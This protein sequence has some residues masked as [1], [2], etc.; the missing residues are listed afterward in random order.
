MRS[1]HIFHNLYP[2]E[3]WVTVE[4]Y[5]PSVSKV[6]QDCVCVYVRVCVCGV[7]VCVCVT[8]WPVYRAVLV[9]N[10]LLQPQ[11][12]GPHPI[13]GADGN[14]PIFSPSVNFSY[15]PINQPKV[16]VVRERYHVV[17]N[18]NLREHKTVV[19]LEMNTGNLD[20][21]GEELILPAPSVKKKHAHTHTHTHTR[22]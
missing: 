19:R 14:G 12:E 4:R 2:Y 9:R 3:H 22:I 11:K 10:T 15:F 17:T 18:V 7:C 5:W 21:D 16:L 8:G 6:S 1:Q 20:T 13:D